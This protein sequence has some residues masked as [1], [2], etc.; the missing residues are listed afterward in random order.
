MAIADQRT[1]AAAA[2]VVG[3]TQS[4]VSLQIKA[5]ESELGV[6]LFDRT[7]RPPVLNAD[8]R[9]LVDRA[10]EIID[11]A[12]QLTQSFRPDSMGSVLALGA[13]PT[14]LTGVLP[15]TLGRL[16]RKIPGLRIRLNGG[17]SHELERRVHVGDLDVAVVTEPEYLQPTLTWR[18]FA[19]EPLMVI[20]PADAEGETD[21][22]LL[23]GT[24]FIRFKR[25]AWA[26]RIID[27]HL[28][29]RGITVDP[30]IEIDS[31]D[32]INMLVANGLGVSIVPQRHVERPFPDG[33]RVVPFGTPPIVRTVGLIERAD[34]TKSA[35][36]SALHQEL[37]SMCGDIGVGTQK[38]R[39][40]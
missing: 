31:L 9:A 30:M 23:T 8:G 7:R 3:L 14:T 39:K 10:R 13:I 12:D 35:L 28:R 29:E 19:A 27:S 20:A 32:G 24:P 5:L 37:V 21:E 25:F 17:L 40:R 15:A 11:L 18:P 22:E 36:S 33:V 16:C 1:F 6:T 38:R 4:A 26:S 34:T 2:Q